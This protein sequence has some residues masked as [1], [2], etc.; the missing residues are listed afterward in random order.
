MQ[1]AD[2]LGLWLSSGIGTSS[3]F[4]GWVRVGVLSHGFGVRGKKLKSRDCAPASDLV[5]TYSFARVEPASRAE[6]KNRERASPLPTKDK[7]C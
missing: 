1:S 2:V 7:V 6:R 5:R 3:A 4:R